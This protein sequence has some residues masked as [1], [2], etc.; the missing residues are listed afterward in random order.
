MESSFYLW[1]VVLPVII[2]KKVHGELFYANETTL[3]IGSE[4]FITFNKSLSVTE[5]HLKILF[6]RAKSPNLVKTENPKSDFLL[7]LYIGFDDGKVDSIK[8]FSRIEGKEKE[9]EEMFEETKTSF[10]SDVHLVISVLVNERDFIVSIQGIKA[11]T[12]MHREGWRQIG[13]IHLSGWPGNLIDKDFNVDVSRHTLYSSRK[14][15]FWSSIIR[16]RH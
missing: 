6:L 11:S 10:E 12:I 15:H 5:G 1:I 4:V 9:P 7:G 8:Y 13:S 16:N 3:S 2:A 14:N